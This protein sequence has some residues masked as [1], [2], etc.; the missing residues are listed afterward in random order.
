[1]VEERGG[2]GG[3]GCFLDI[4]KGVKGGTDVSFVFIDVGGE[5]KK[6]RGGNIERVVKDDVVG[7]WFRFRIGEDGVVLVVRDEFRDDSLGG[8]VVVGGEGTKE[9]KRVQSGLYG[10]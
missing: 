2:F 8:V 4:R 7:R 6:F 10:V 9:G 5:C 3:E 1:M